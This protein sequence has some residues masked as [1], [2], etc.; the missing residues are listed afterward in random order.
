MQVGGFDLP[1]G[2]FGDGALLTGIETLAQAEASGAPSISLSGGRVR[3][4]VGYRQATATNQDPVVIKYR[5]GNL[6]WSRTDY[7]VSTADAR[8]YGIHWAELGELLVVF[9]STGS[10][11]TADEDFRRF[12]V[13]GWLSGPGIGAAPPVA[14]LA[15]IRES[16][17][18]VTAATY[19][20]SQLSNGNPNFLTVTDLAVRQDGRVEVAAESGF[21]PLKVDGTPFDC[22]GVAASPIPYR[23]V[24]T[25]DLRAALEAEA[26]GCS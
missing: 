14:V 23:V 2:D 18:E 25:N 12:T 3:Y 20:R 5:N 22:S 9:E 10:G 15:R 21:S 24:L 16:D 8:A 19:L 11:G 4:F 26:P 6:E 17:G 13:D 1:T 7:E